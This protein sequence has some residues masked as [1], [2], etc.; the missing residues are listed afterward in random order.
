MSEHIPHHPERNLENKAD[1]L[2]AQENN[3]KKNAEITDADSL[4]IE[5]IRNQIENKA[6]SRDETSIDRPT[7]VRTTEHITKDIKNQS[8]AKT[9]KKI[10]THL[11]KSLRAFS[12]TVHQP[13]IEKISNIGA[14]TI[15]RSSGIMG[16]SIAAL[17]GSVSLLFF[18]KQYGFTYNYFVLF[19][20]FGIGFMIGLSIELLTKIFRPKKHQ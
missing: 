9:L 15:A 18:S 3:T 7:T 1:K 6:V 4:N 2:E 5:N 14:Q 17:V 20:L 11:P 10:R 19:I 13:S 16:G 12:S 8:Y